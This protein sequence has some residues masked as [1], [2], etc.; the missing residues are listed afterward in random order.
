MLARADND[1]A[2]LERKGDPELRMSTAS[3]RW[4]SCLFGEGDTEVRAV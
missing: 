4:N 3:T 1:D 2:L